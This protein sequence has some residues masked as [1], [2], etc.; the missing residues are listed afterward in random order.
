MVP[1]YDGDSLV[2]LVAELE[3]R[4]TGSSQSPRLHP[5]TIRSDSPPA[6]LCAVPRRRSRR[7]S[8]AIPSPGRSAPRSAPRHPHQHLSFHHRGGAVLH[9]HRSHSPRPWGARLP[10]MVP[11]TKSGTSSTG[12]RPPPASASGSTPS[13]S[14]PQPNLWE[15]LANHNTLTW[16]HLPQELASSPMTRML[17]RGAETVPYW[18]PTD[19]IS[20]WG[21]VEMSSPV[22]R[23]T[24]RYSSSTPIVQ[25]GSLISN[26]DYLVQGGFRRSW[27]L[28]GMGPS[29]C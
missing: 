8:T 25:A 12:G 9:L 22:S 4:L 20:P 28:S 13:A 21:W 2:N 11:Y 17:Y 16:V 15:R 5:R 14:F 24:R 29:L 27:M 23:S 19:I 7:P 10:A 6:Q 18:T 3:H 1:S 26:L